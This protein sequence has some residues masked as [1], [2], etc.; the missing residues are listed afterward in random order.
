MEIEYTHRERVRNLRGN[1]ESVCINSD[2][3]MLSMHEELDSFQTRLENITIN[4]QLFTSH[5]SSQ[6]GLLPVSLS[7]C[8]L[9][10]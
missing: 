9:L 5:M 8:D 6:N 4:A 1:S 2:C 3:C 10:I 7:S